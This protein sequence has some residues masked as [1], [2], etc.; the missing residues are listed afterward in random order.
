MVKGLQELIKRAVD[1]PEFRRRLLA[2][3]EEV[4]STEGYQIDSETIAKLKKTGEAPP[5]AIDALVERLRRSEGRA[6]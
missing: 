6:G 4:V 5:E 1:D 3:P 2:A